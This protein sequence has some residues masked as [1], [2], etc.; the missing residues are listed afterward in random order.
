MTG[1]L[2]IYKILKNLQNIEIFSILKNRF[3]FKKLKKVKINEIIH[4]A[5]NPSFTIILVTSHHNQL[6]FYYNL[7]IILFSGSFKIILRYANI[8]EKIK[9]SVQSGINVKLITVSVWVNIL[10]NISKKTAT[11]GVA[12]HNRL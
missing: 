12:K 8:F 1:N 11:K 2:K 3:V 10:Y 7:R 6:P 5:E 9:L 4:S